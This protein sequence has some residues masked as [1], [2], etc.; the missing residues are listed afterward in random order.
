[1]RARRD[2]N[3]HIIDIASALN[4]RAGLRWVAI[5]LT[6]GRPAGNRS[7][8]PRSSVSSLPR[9][10][11]AWRRDLTPGNHAEGPVW[12]AG[13]LSNIVYYFPIH[14]VSGFMRLTR[15]WVD[16]QRR[17]VTALL[18][19]NF[20]KAGA[21]FPYRQRDRVCPSRAA[22]HTFAL[23]A[24]V[25]VTLTARKI[26]ERAKRRITAFYKPSFSSRNRQQNFAE[27]HFAGTTWE[28]ERH[29][30][31]ASFAS[32]HGSKTRRAAVLF[33]LLAS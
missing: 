21:S 1:M 24:V 33:A 7:D 2:H 23:A 15:A 10:P 16:V 3:S 19:Q 4:Q 22:R 5:T 20:Q 13:I 14:S 26:K 31:R 9:P 18:P 6:N 8:A 11:P 17:G 30:G 25:P 12:K 27:I 32:M 28:G 29:S